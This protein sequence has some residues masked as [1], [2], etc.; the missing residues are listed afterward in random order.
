MKRRPIIFLPPSKA[1]EKLDD[2]E[3]DVVR[4]IFVADDAVERADILK[5]GQGQRLYKVQGQSSRFYTLPIRN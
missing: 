2:L 3:D 5:R 4:D 1:S